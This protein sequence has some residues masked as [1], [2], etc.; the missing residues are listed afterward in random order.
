[1]R[2]S[3]AHKLQWT[4]PTVHSSTV[5]RKSECS[6]KIQR[7][8]VIFTEW[9]HEFCHHKIDFIFCLVCIKCMCLYGQDKK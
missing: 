7:H 2:N 9:F 1:M 8:F 6:L 3:R 4:D 5:S